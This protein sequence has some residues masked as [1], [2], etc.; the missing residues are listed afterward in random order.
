MAEIWQRHSVRPARPSDRQFDHNPHQEGPFRKKRNSYDPEYENRVIFLERALEDAEKKIRM[1]GNLARKVSDLERKNRKLE[2]SLGDA[3]IWIKKLR[4]RSPPGSCNEC[5][6][7]ELKI[8][9]LE[10]SNKIMK[11]ALENSER[12]IKDLE[13]QID[14]S[15]EKMMD[16][17][18]NAGSVEVAGEKNLH[19]EDNLKKAEE[20]IK[21]L[22]Q[23]KE[24]A[25]NSGLDPDSVL[26][27]RKTLKETEKKVEHFQS[28]CKRLEENLQEATKEKEAFEHNLKNVRG[29][30]DTLTRDMK[31]KEEHSKRLEHELQSKLK[32]LREKESDSV[33]LTKMKQILNEGNVDGKLNFIS[34]EISSLSS[35][36]KEINNISK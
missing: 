32:T 20:R 13:E 22:E 27:L 2:R 10:K 3:E 14:D 19:L 33:A 34:Q 28:T 15:A 25:R 31:K 36:L 12:R 18:N 24:D 1:D 5:N 16:A 8:D 23:E 9:K 6:H 4:K 35:V 29:S 11:N 30:M 7:H 17:Y 21:E 26:H